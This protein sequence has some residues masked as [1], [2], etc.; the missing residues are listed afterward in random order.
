MERQSKKL[1]IMHLMLLAAMLPSSGTFAQ[2]GEI[3][4]Q[5]MQ[6][7]EAVRET[8]DENC[9]ACHGYDGVPMLPGT[10]NFIAGERLE[11]SDDEL[12]TTIAQGK[13]LMPPWEGEL[14]VEQRKQLL[15]YIRGFAGE[16]V[17]QS[18]CSSC[19]EDSVPANTIPG[20]RKEVLEYAGEIDF[21]TSDIEASMS[22][23]DVADVLDFLVSLK[24]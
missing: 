9:A 5:D 16:L 24:Q 22:R 10:P 7:H 19:H 12:L 6:R 1:L 18:K 3:S 23:K 17:F 13:D 4:E 15:N 14:T 11:R 20:K 2:S 8:F 21:C